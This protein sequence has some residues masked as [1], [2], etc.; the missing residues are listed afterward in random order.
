MPAPE[1]TDANASAAPGG[2]ISR[3]RGGAPSQGR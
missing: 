2:A 3:G 1:Q